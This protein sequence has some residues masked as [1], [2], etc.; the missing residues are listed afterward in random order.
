MSCSGGR[1][2]DCGWSIATTGGEIVFMG[3]AGFM[4]DL[5]GLQG[6]GNIQAGVVWQGSTY[7]A[8]GAFAV[9]DEGA[10]LHQYT[11]LL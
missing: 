1:S 10:G 8:S 7:A 5:A 9:H 4:D 2:S 3:A 6:L 11:L